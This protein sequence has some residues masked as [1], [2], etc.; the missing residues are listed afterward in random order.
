[1]EKPGNML[2]IRRGQVWRIDRTTNY[3]TVC[4]VDD[5]RLFMKD[6]NGYITEWS[7]DELTNLDALRFVGTIQ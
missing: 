6:C 3:L 7:Y 2:T 4:D 1:M 5:D